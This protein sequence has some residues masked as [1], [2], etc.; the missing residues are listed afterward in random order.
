MLI[1]GY[2][3]ITERLT[4][5]RRV[6]RKGS[7]KINIHVKGHTKGGN[8]FHHNVVITHKGNLYDAKSI[9]IES[10]MNSVAPLSESE[11]EQLELEGKSHST[12]DDPDYITEGGFEIFKL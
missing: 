6:G 10:I 5:Y 8:D 12:L 7:W 3:F 9:A 4:H 1:V 11:I 2:D